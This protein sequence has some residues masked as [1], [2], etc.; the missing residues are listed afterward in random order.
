M[1][2]GKSGKVIIEMDP[3][4][5]RQLYA[6]L[7]LEGITMKDWFLQNAAYYIESQGQLR[8]P[9]ETVGADEK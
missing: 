8:F 2:V 1:A 7:S 3:D 9:L 5:K 6:A 4:L